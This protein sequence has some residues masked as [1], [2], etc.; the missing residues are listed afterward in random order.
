MKSNAILA[1]VLL[2]LSARPAEMLA[3][4]PRND[5][6]AAFKAGNDLLEQHKPAEALLKYKAGLALEP[7]D[8]SLLYNAGLAAFSSGD[9]VSASGFWKHLKDLDRL[10]WRTRAKLVQTYQAL[11]KTPERNAE[12]AELFALRKSGESE[13]LSKAIE[14]CRE[15][16]AV[17]GQK[18]MAFEEFELKGERALRYVFSVLNQEGNREEYRISLGSY[19]TTN[20]IWHETTKPTPK[21]E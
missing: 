3:Q 5:A 4:T 13:E 19:D 14:Y 17:N 1:F 21:P 10:D 15:Q 7:D 8:T 12:R 6:D 9:Y 2:A 18:V 11:N 16:F 20:A